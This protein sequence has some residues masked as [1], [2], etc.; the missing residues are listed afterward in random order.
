MNRKLLLNCFRNIYTYIYNGLKFS[1]K[2]KEKVFKNNTVI[3]V[4]Q[5]KKA[6]RT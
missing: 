4:N 2:M 6:K 5:Y 1:K 3:T